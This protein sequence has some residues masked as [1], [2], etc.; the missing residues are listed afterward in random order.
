MPRREEAARP[1]RPTCPP[2]SNNPINKCICFSQMLSVWADIVS[3]IGFPLALIGLWVAI[4]ETKKSKSAAVAAGIAV[5]KVRKDISLINT[6][7]EFSSA[8][9]ILDESKRLIRHNTFAPLPDRLT[10]ARLLLILIREKT[11]NL[12]EDQKICFQDAI[13]DLSILEKKI[14]EIISKSGPLK[15]APAVNENIS[16]HIDKLYIVLISI[17]ESIGKDETHGTK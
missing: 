13:S 7:S 15:N 9:A 16:N 10:Q 1:D 3:L 11:K 2:T 8:I 4:R 5:E 6:V 14:E 17:K 12:T